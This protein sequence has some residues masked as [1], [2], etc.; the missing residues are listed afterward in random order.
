MS[1]SPFSGFLLFFTFPI[2]YSFLSRFFKRLFFSLPLPNRRQTKIRAGPWALFD[3]PDL[4]VLR[5]AKPKAGARQIYHR[6]SEPRLIQAM[7]HPVP[8]LL[9]LLQPSA[10]F[11]STVNRGGNRRFFFTYRERFHEVITRDSKQQDCSY[12][13]GRRRSFIRLPS[14][15]CLCR[16]GNGWPL[17]QGSEAVW[18]L[19]G[20]KDG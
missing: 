10:V 18:A 20:S 13:W 12:R 9:Q 3:D 4:A 14:V 17:L 15:M 2:Q 1:F 5:Y 19:Q 6:I 8:H 11:V 7:D 16:H